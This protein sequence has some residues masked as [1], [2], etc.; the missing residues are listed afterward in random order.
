MVEKIRKI[1]PVMKFSL[2]ETL[3]SMEVDDVIFIKWNMSKPSTIR[4][5]AKRIAGNNKQFYISEAGLV[6][7]TKVL[8]VK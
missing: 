6:N 3:K 4:L 5:S 7:K 1:K 8:R 2:T